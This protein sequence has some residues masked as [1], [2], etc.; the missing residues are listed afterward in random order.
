MNSMIRRAV[1]AAVFSGGLQ[2]AMAQD[3]G[4][5]PEEPA[6]GALQEIVVTAQKRETNLQET[7][8]SVAVLSADALNDRQAI[9]LASLADGSVPSLRV[10]PFATRTSALNINIRGIGASGDANQPARDAGV[11]VYVD[12]VFLGRAQGLGAALYDIER[13]E[14]LKGP[15]GTLFGRNT[16]G[17]AISIVTRA[18][19]GEFGL[20]TRFGL[21]NFDGYYGAFHL[22]LP[23][24]GDFSF[25]IDGLVNR[26][27]GTTDNPVAGEAD[28][29][30][31]DKRGIRAAALWQPADDLSVSYAYDNSYDATTPFH[32][33]LLVAGPLASPLQRAG[34]SFQRRDSSI[35]GGEQEESVGRNS[36]HT[37][38]VD[39]TPNDSLQ[40]KS[41]SSYRDLEQGQL[42][43]GF[44]DWISTFAPNRPFARY[45]LAQ[46]KQHQYSQELQLVGRTRQVEY[47]AGAFYYHES[48]ADD[49]QTPVMNLW[50]ATGTA[51]VPNP[52]TTPLDLSRVPIDRA[53]RAYTDSLGVF[54]QATWTPASLERLHLTAGGRY[55]QDDKNGRLLI[56]NGAPSSLAFD[57][58]WSRF[59][60]MVTVA[61]DL[62]DST[63]LYGKWSTG[64]RAGGANS[65]S[66]T[67]R[68]F[69]P[70]EVSAFELGLKSQFWDD[71]ARLNVALFDAEI[72]D[73]QV[74]FFFPLATNATRTVS[75]T[76]NAT[77]STTSR[78]LELELALVPIDDLT[79]SL[80]YTLTDVD[81]LDAPNP[82]VAGNPLV[83]VLP[84]YAPENAGSVALDYLVPIGGTKLRFHIDGNW[85]DG[86][87][88]SEVEQTL[89]DSSFI[90]NSRLALAEVQLAGSGASAE[91]SLWARNLLDEKF[92]FY[93]SINPTL[94]DVGI[95]NEPR[96]YG[97]EARV[98]F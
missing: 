4:A 9:S 11:G 19:T 86:F 30:S 76:T 24:I 26:R 42:D 49:A 21:A 36:G 68:P 7:P 53:S 12:G 33:Q 98:R 73:K 38:V 74:D 88:A 35:L 80:N 96:T 91:F 18:P 44:I 55:T 27:D 6:S 47:V 59:D 65:R 1:L 14:V 71:R 52:A 23:R 94:G 39:W 64:F 28:F 48:A 87:F 72:N 83:R 51:F 93:R 34:A 75:D 92:L 66:L 37:L 58:S 31:W 10:V 13:I 97:I 57:D 56:L 67:Y 85:S 84:L 17:G 79:L 90:V 45:S 89:T 69:A 25:K 40:L 2:P 43:Q 81:P 95:F 54:A 50:N 61:Y 41:I 5:A 8:I 3:G 77:T 63:M 60:P 15:Q 82:Y 32:A 22:N 70:E 29:N 16:M 78:G 46:V 20:D 62:R